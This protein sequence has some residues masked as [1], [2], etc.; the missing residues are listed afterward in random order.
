MTAAVAVTIVLVTA[1][2]STR[3]RSAAII[4]KR[5]AADHGLDA[6]PFPGT[7]D[8]SPSAQITFP[9]LL[10]SELKSVTVTGSSSGR[11]A[12]RLLALPGRR[13]TAFVPHRKFSAGEH[14]TVKARLSSPAAGTAT[15]A[16]LKTEVSFSFQV[17][18]PAPQATKWPPTGPSPGPS[19]PAPTLSFHSRPDLHPPTIKL[20]ANDHDADDTSGDFFVSAGGGLMVLNSH[21]QLVWFDDPTQKSHLSVLNLNLQHY[22]GKPVLTWWQGKLVP[23]GYG[24][25]GEDVI[26]N[27]AYQR[28]GTV[29]G[30]EGYS[31]DLHE[32]QLTKNGT[33]LITAF[34]P[35]HADLSSVGG[36][37]N[38]WVLDSIVQEI[39]VRTG[40]LLW[41]WHAL[42][43][44]PISASEAGKP[45]ADQPYDYFHINSI[46]QLPNG[47][48]LVS[49]RN[50]WA[51]YEISRAT[52]HVLWA[53]GG[54]NSSFA[55]GSGSNFFWQHDAELHSGSLLTLFDDGAKPKK[56]N[57]S[58]ALEINLDLHSMRASL[59]HAYTHSPPLLASA[60]GNVQL[61]PNGN[62]LVGWG[63][64]PAFSEYA[65]SGKQIWDGL[66]TPP[67]DSYRAYR[68]PW[69]AQ[70]TTHPAISVSAGS[71]GAVTVYASWNGATDVAR[72]QLLAGKNKNNLAPVT[73][74][75]KTGFET[76][77]HAK[78]SDHY[79]AARA[80]SDSGRVL[81]T[82]EVTTR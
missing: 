29:R 32:F 5:T 54:K 41:A 45:Q 31:A 63:T 67:N 24:A 28:V 7:P 66:F 12:G 14:V 55:M 39:D 40:R 70:P 27:R 49:A 61:L 65:P 30:A 17:A 18:R 33:A 9:A 19:K 56:E 48:L 75:K 42:G 62:V 68:S 26:L 46:Q 35:V 76:T 36:P 4:P 78:T 53:L 6:L 60:E 79:L 25:N 3:P 21:G 72:W 37:R 59:K 82:S 51:V 77:I 43:H 22:R 71:G 80:L 44:V 52:G 69:K 10:P 11:H 38:G 15:G 81:G 58:R 20:T 16:P 74:I 2:G 64:A 1:P 8:A 34:S 13:G 73:T 57:Q 50:T 23:P 47:N